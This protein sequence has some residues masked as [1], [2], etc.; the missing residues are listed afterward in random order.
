MTTAWPA[1]ALA[2]GVWF[3]TALAAVAAPFAAYVMD[4][5]SG[6]VLYSENADTRLHPASLTKMMTLYITFEAIKRGEISLDTMVTVS[7]NAASE[8]PSKL[9]LRTGQKIALRYLIRAA[10]V[11]SANDCATAIGEAVGGSETKFAARMNRTAAALGMKNTT[12]RNANGLTA[13]GHRSTAHD[14]ALLGRHLFYDHPEFYNIFSRRSTDAGVSQVYSTNRR[15]LDSYAGADG[16]KTG[17]TGPAGFNLVASADRGGVRIIAAV[18]GGTSTAQRNAKMTQLLDLG[19]KKAPRGAPVRK[20]D[21]PTY[22]VADA[23]LGDDGPEDL[24]GA[25]DKNRAAGKTLRLQLAV[26]R[27]PRPSA[28]PDTTVAMRDTIASV[29]EDVTADATPLAVAAAEVQVATAEDPAPAR[30]PEALV[31]A[32]E[33]AEPTALP[34]PEGQT[35]LAADAG[36]AGLDGTDL[37]GTVASAIVSDVTEATAPEPVEESVELAA[38]A[39]SAGTILPRRRPDPLKLLAEPVAAAAQQAA[40]EVVS[41]MSTSGGRF[42]SI[43]LGKYPSPAEADRVLLKTALAES[44]VLGESLRKVVRR[45]TG[46]EANFVGLSQDS[47]DLAC[48]RLQARRILCFTV[49][50]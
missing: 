33:V 41:R 17:Y 26:T 12:F 13:D 7:R 4:A 36:P 11:K 39:P 2:A 1:A 28:R 38:L 9:G 25:G 45:K 46:W 18:F 31:A 48:R 40:P 19:F 14:M 8:P 50:P 43:T 42:W 27:S 35:V 29:L 5:R 15:F 37:V 16:I 47:A 44:G 34:V 24:A 20:P 49:S 6:Q 21:L 30:R 3:V 10:A 22:L 32:P 23:D